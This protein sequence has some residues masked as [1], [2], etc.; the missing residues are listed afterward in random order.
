MGFGWSGLEFPVLVREG[1]CTMEDRL[2]RTPSCSLSAG[3]GLEPGSEG[4]DMSHPATIGG[5]RSP[6]VASGLSPAETE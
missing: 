1:T 2:A 3:R 6:A 4:M 5:G